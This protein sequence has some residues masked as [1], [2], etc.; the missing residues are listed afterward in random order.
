[1]QIVDSLKQVISLS[2]GEAGVKVAMQE[3]SLV[4]PKELSR[5]DYA[6]GVALQ[7][8]KQASVSPVKLA[9]QIAAGIG[10]INGVKRVEVASPGFIN[11]HLESSVIWGVVGQ[12][13]K[14]A[15]SWGENDSQ[16][17]KR[18]MVEYTDPNPFKEFHIGHLMSNA[19]GESIARLL[20]YT[21][22]RVARANYQGDIGPHVAKA[23]WSI[24][25]WRRRA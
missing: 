11:F 5:G 25:K 6:T 16:K 1:M 13:I 8:A 19:I 14:E 4:R 10:K 17:G 2:L 23:V 20:E 12:A 21:G 9:E 15:E 3:I 18:V 24:Q 22:A 7:Y